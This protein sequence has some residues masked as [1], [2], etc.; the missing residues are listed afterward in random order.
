MQRIDG[1]YAGRSC[2]DGILDDL[3]MR[4]FEDLFI[5]FV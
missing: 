4:I 3:I 2:H 1:T 5:L